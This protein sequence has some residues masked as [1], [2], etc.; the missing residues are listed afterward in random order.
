MP[1]PIVAYQQTC[2]LARNVLRTSV[3]GTVILYYTTTD[4]FE[5]TCIYINGKQAH[6]CPW[7]SK[8]VL[9]QNDHIADMGPKLR[10]TFILLLFLNIKEYE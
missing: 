3:C 8:I 5:T 10:L 6:F 4:I 7:K 2:A 9:V 1:V